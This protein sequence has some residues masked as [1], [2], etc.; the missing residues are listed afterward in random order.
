MT[1]IHQNSLRASL[2]GAFKSGTYSDMTVVSGGREF[3]V[4]Q[5]II[6]PRST[7]FAAACN[8][9]FQVAPSSTVIGFR[10]TVKGINYEKDLVGR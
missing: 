3:K 8:G 4:H 6:C 9:S 10:L 5:L 7:F 2:S 1:D